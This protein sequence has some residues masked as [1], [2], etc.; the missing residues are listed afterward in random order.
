MCDRLYHNPVYVGLIAAAQ[1]IPFLLLGPFAGTL[2][3][4]SDRQRIMLWADIGS[5]IV[6]AGF[7]VWLWIDPHPPFVSMLIASA[8]LSCVN[9]FFLPAKTASIPNL[10]PEH[11]LV[12]A[13][14][15]SQTTQNFMPFVG[16]ALSGIGLSLLE[17]VMGNAFFMT[18]VIVNAIT[19][20]F[21]GWQIAKL[22]AI[23]PD[24]HDADESMLIQ[25][26]NG[27]QYVSCR[28]WLKA[29][30]FLM[31]MMQLSVSPFMI[32]YVTVNRE[33]FGGEFWKL[34]LCEAT[35]L[36]GLVVSSL[37]LSRL[38]IR[39]VGI[40]GVFGL[41]LCGLF[42]AFMGISKVYWVYVMWNIACGLALPFFQIPLQAYI[43]GALDDAYR[44]R[45]SSLISMGANAVI[46]LGAMVVGGSL[47]KIGLSNVFFLMG[48]VALLPC[49]VALLI[50]EFRNLEAKPISK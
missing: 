33:W 24:A 5:A 46:P 22:P 34:A 18:A 38:T 15:I 17:R 4:R 27:W 32:V 50:P 6:L 19:F 36:L 37:F 41:G 28:T 47:Q 21:S 25:L 10:V 39:K 13:T 8:L 26:K 23:I 3:D 14:A 49:L 31:L 40:S 43:Y 7:T 35:F 16:L 1:A 12:D 42:I 30:A 29:Y 9:S 2:A 44:G 20:L 48:L 11:Q 45:V